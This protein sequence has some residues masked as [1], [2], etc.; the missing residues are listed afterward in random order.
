MHESRQDILEILVKQRNEFKPDLVIGP[1]QNDIHQDHLV[2]STEMIRAFK[3]TS[4]I[5]SYELPWNHLNF[6]TQLFVKLSKDIVN[7][8][9]E[10]LS[11]YK[12][13]LEKNRKYFSQEYI[14]GL[15]CVRG[16]QAN[17]DYAESFEIIRWLI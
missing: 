9:I 2:V 5:I 14:T 12:T 13:Q 4:S 17:T 7:K 1:S 8:K 11:N 16:I 6:N 10:L 15:A 3:N